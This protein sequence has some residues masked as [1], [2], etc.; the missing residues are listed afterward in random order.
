MKIGHVFRMIL[1]VFLIF[2]LIL[3]SFDLKTVAASDTGF[4]TK[5][6][7]ELKNFIKK[8]GGTV[9]LQYKDLTTGEVV[10]IN[11]KTSGRA[12]S[13]IKL[14]LAIY[15][16]EQA[17]KGKINL[18]KKLKYKSYHYYGG[19]GIIQHKKVGT[20]FTIRDLV[21]YAMIYSDN[22][23]F[24]MLKEYIGPGNFIKYMKS[25][26]GQYA[27]PKGQNLTSANDLTI[28]AAKLYQ[29]AGKSSYGKEL[30][31]YLEKTV[32]NTT[33]P[34]GI[35]GVPVAHKVGM[36]PEDRIY[37]DAAIVYDKKPF[38]L[39]V[40]TRNISYAKSQK[41]IA[42]LAAI[43]YKHHKAKN[44]TKKGETIKNME[45]RSYFRGNINYSEIYSGS[46]LMKINQY[47]PSS[48][49]VQYSFD[50]NSN[51]TIKH[52]EKYNKKTHKVTS[53]Y[54]YYPNTVYGRHG[55]NIKYIFDVN[56]SG[57]VIK[58]SK[59]EKGTKRILSRYQY[60]PEADYGSHG[61]MIKYIF[62]LDSLGHV[63]KASKREQ[64]TKR[65]LSMYEYY[66]NTVYGTHGK[67]IKYIYNL[68]SS[69]RITKGTFRE[70]GTMRI[71]SSY[72]YNLK[73]V[74]GKQLPPEVIE[75]GRK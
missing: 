73:V 15:I 37:N 74:Y 75:K 49:S 36:I 10:Q 4:S 56:S 48:K 3:P 26:G 52:A 72:Q 51:G 71:L 53:H 54:E 45:I 24:I 13:T 70:R 47:Y 62:V 63:K 33:I 23:A 34:R 66:P 9:T 61:M 64:G 42:D 2:S 25:L 18:N 17:S 6:S 30:V 1:V 27:Y 59:R 50:M 60:Y 22:I 28:Y 35:K 58:A 68:D 21:K 43:V 57:D 19:S 44:A 11:G 20:Y 12:A 67:N 39:A 5:L 31:G 16:M 7:S 38:V 14:P 32:Y 55:G 69:G 8:T 65:I 40:M 46:K 29:F 41:V